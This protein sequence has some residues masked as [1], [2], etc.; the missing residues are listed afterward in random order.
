[1]S[2]LDELGGRRSDMAAPYWKYLTRCAELEC[3]NDHRCTNAM[4]PQIAQDLQTIHNR[5]GQI[6]QDCR[7]AILAVLHYEIHMI[8]LWCTTEIDLL[9]IQRTAGLL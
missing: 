9:P 2:R 4:V 3:G 1:M 5:L 7:D 8:M 6:D